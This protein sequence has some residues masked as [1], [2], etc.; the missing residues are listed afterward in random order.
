M[1]PNARSRSSV[2]VRSSPAGLVVRASVATIALS[3]GEFGK[4]RAAAPPKSDSEPVGNGR[5]K[6]RKSGPASQGSRPNRGPE[7]EQRNALARMVR[8]RRGRI[9]PVVGGDEEQIVLA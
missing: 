8:A 3:P 4:E 2:S 6:I 7:H 5:A 9:V 1:A